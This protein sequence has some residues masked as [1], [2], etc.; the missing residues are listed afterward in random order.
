MQ[1]MTIPLAVAIKLCKKYRTIHTSN[2]PIQCWNCLEASKEDVAK[3]Y[4]YNPPKHDGCDIVNKLYKM[5]TENRSAI[6]SC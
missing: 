4:F 6:C 2:F 5:Y 3:M 1:N